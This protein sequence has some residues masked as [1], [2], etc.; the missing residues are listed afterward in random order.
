MLLMEV[1]KCWKIVEFPKISIKK[2]KTFYKDKKRA[3]LGRLFSPPNPPNKNF[4][5]KQPAAG[6]QSAVRP[7]VD[8]RKSPGGEPRGE[9]RRRSVYLGSENL[10]LSLKINHLFLF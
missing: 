4:D 8:P 2:F 1:L 10:L 3:T 7:P 6:L 5:M 9:A